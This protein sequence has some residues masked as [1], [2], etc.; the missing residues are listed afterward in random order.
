MAKLI[1][2]GLL[3]RSLG[4]GIQADKDNLPEFYYHAFEIEG[5]FD[6]DG[7]VLWARDLLHTHPAM[8]PD[9]FWVV[10]DPAAN[11]KI[12]SALLLIPQ[13]WRYE[14][15]EIPCG[16]VEIVATLPEY[17]RRGLVR[18]LMNALHEHSAACGHLLQSITGIPFY[19]RQF[20]YG[21]TLNLGAGFAFP[22]RLINELKEDEIPIYR[23]R[24][25]SE[26]D[27][28]ALMAI[29][30]YA[31]QSALVSVIRDEEMWRYDLGG[32]RQKAYNRFDTF[33]IVDNSDDAVGYVALS[34]LSNIDTHETAIVCWRYVLSDLANYIE[35][36]MDVLR[37]IKAQALAAS[38]KI[39]GLYFTGNNH[40]IVSN[41]IGNTGGAAK[42]ENLYSWYIRLGDAVAFFKAIAPVLERRLHGS[43]AHGYS[44]TLRFG[45]YDFTC[46]QFVF[47]DGKLDD[48]ILGERPENTWWDGEFPYHSFLSI[49]FGYRTLHDIKHILP[50]AWA[51]RHATVL[52]DILFP[53]KPSMIFAVG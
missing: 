7:L 2:D 23:L 45:F 51:N 19:Y 13:I 29:D 50:D 27:I 14:E 18:E 48:V 24:A 10:V 43:G 16:R 12:V 6:S 1:R 30:E 36:F 35:T 47:A 22:F 42:A 38:D 11:G 34:D 20:G 53:K 25:A 28:S 39:A 44:G 17:R 52:L 26:E 41:L 5:D 40:P 33:M 31:A 9:D 32:R 46:L 49:V 15:I 4:E 3:L 37:A 21:M 8:S